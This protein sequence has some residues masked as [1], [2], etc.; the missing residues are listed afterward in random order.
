MQVNSS[1]KNIIFDLGVVLLNIDYSLTQKAFRQLGITDF[2]ALYSQ[3]HQ[4]KIFD[5]FEKGLISAAEFRNTLRKI[6]D[7]NWSDAQIDAAWNAM[8]LDFPEKRLQLLEKLKSRY[9]LS[10]LSNTNEIHINYFSNYLQKTFGIADLSN[11]FEKEYFSYEIKMRKPDTEIYE[12]VLREKKIL[13]QETLFID[14]L[15]I[16][17]KA[18]ET[19]GLQTIHLASPN[20]ILDIIFI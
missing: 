3:L 17:V 6:S 10:L 8:L 4:D 15:L 11:V 7:K 13:A 5:D 18:A 12:Y 2:D 20:T 16:N 1:V 14:D 9:R 19:I